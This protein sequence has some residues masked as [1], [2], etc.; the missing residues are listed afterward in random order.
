M[1]IKHFSGPNV[2]Y[3]SSM[4]FGICGIESVSFPSTSETTYGEMQNNWN[5]V[6]SK[7]LC[8]SVVWSRTN[9]INGFV[10]YDFV[11]YIQEHG[12]NQMPL[13]TRS[14]FS[15]LSEAISG[16]KLDEN[17]NAFMNRGISSAPTIHKIKFISLSNSKALFSYLSI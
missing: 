11:V 10:G 5:T 4:A 8:V 13:R 7:E 3:I 12:T 6:N 16:L 17:G 2:K 15:S 1:W 9:G 14:H